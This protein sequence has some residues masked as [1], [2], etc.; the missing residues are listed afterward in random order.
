MTG[1][2]RGLGN[3]C[4]EERTFCFGFFGKREEGA[5]LSWMGQRRSKLESMCFHLKKI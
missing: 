2:K 4:Q 1:C 5:F 3:G